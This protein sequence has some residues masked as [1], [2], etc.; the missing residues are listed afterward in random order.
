MARRPA[1][2]ARPRLRHIF[3]R[4]IGPPPACRCARRSA[5]AAAVCHASPMRPLPRCPHRG[6]APP[7]A[8]AAR[9]GGR[10]LRP[11]GP[12]VPRTCRTRSAI[13]AAALGAPRGCHKLHVH[14]H[15]FERS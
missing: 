8:T 12:A 9:A 5:V 7:P 4:G 10:C 13:L 6:V 2:H 15:N 1:C 11:S 14:M 3:R